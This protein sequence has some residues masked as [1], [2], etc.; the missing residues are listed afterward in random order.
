MGKDSSGSST[1][2]S[3]SKHDYRNS[4]LY[5]LSEQSHLG[6][7]AKVILV[8]SPK[9]QYVPFYSARLQVI[10]SHRASKFVLNPILLLLLLL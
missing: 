4:F 1:P 3:S 8:A 9:D 10:S 2:A 5:K 6:K 7:F